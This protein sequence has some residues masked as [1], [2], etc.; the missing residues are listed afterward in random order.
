MP[1]C[2]TCLFL[3]KVLWDFFHLP[4]QGLV[5]PLHSKI[6]VCLELWEAAGAVQGWEPLSQDCAVICLCPGLPVPSQALC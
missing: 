1:L 4:A 5:G 6:L 3:L 2:E